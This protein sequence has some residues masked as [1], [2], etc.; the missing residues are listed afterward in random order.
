M[1]PESL[2]AAGLLHQ[3]RAGR[4][5]HPEP[6]RRPQ[7]PDTGH[8]AGAGRARRALPEE[9]RVVVVR[10][11]GASFS[12]GWTGHARPTAAPVTSETVAG[13]LAARRARSRRPSTPTS[14]GS[15]SC[16]TRGSSRSRR[17]RGYAIGAGFQLALAC[18]LRVVADDAQFAMKESALGLVPDLT[19]TKP[20]VESV[21]Y[22]RALEICVTAADGRRSRGRGDRPGT[23]RRTRGR[24]GRGRGRSRRG[25]DRALPGAVSETKALLPVA[26]SATSTSSGD[27]SARPRYA[28][29]VSWPPWRRPLDRSRRVGN[30]RER[31]RLAPPPLRPERVETRIDPKTI[32]RVLAFARPHRRHILA[33]LAFTVINAG[34]VVVTPLLI[35]RIVDDGIAEGDRRLVTASRSAMALTALVSALVGVGEGYF[36]VA[37]RRGADLRPAHRLRATSSA[38]RSR[39]SPA[40]RPARSSRRLNNDVIGAQRAFTSTLSGTVANTISVVVVGITMFALSWQVTLLCLALFPLL[41]LP[42]VGRRPACRPDP[43]PDGRQRRPRQHHDR[44]VQ[45]RRRDAAQALRPSRARGRELRAEGRRG[46]RPRG[47]DRADQPGVRR[48]HDRWSRRWRPPWST[49]SA[50]SCDQRH[51]ARWARWSRSPPAAA[52][53]RARSRASPTSAST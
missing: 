23:D 7:R 5:H 25:P 14:R 52:A 16:A 29:S 24:A 35:Q 20:L 13:L 17:C 42:R 40:P 1:T 31:R 22:A 15:R 26:P 50:A 36:S 18:D 46:P 10:G 4:H 8:V 37:G 6:S 45:R 38:S 51:P 53:A 2:A 21:G 39:S 33:F 32:R 9:T 11:A 28:G 34:L 43:A 44:A 47:A 30:A 49:A 3:R 19:G 41:L 48:R 27:W 12:A